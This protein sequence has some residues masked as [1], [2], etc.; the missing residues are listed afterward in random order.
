MDEDELCGQQTLE[1][2]V[3][4]Q[5]EFPQA[6]K[7]CRVESK[8]RGE[9]HNRHFRLETVESGRHCK[10]SWPSCG[11][12]GYTGRHRHLTGKVAG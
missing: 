11:H 4:A 1:K 8:L 2:H 3:R 10:R 7:Q 9:D 5:S 12:A 6:H